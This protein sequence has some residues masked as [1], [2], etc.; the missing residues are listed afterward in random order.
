MSKTDLDRTI[1]IGQVVAKQL[2]QAKAALVSHLF[3]KLHLCH[4]AKQAR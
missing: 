3:C 4:N 2:P 1:V